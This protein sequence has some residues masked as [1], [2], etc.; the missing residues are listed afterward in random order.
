[1]LHNLFV[2]VFFK[3][4][5]ICLMSGGWAGISRVLDFLKLESQDIVTDLMW[6]LGTEQKPLVR[7]ESN[8]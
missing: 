5:V 4:S 7:K 2:L 3:D 1:M 8:H 6:E